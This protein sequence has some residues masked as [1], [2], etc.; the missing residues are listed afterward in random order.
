MTIRIANAE[1]FIEMLSNMSTIM[2]KSSVKVTITKPKELSTSRP[3]NGV[4]F[5]KSSL[6]RK[7]TNLIAIK[8]RSP[9]GVC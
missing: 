3:F 8:M 1:N 9:L 2:K 7:V 6:S 4:L 5:N